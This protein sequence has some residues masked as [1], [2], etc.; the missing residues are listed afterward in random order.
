MAI[1]L[2]T[3]QMIKSRQV[4]RRQKQ[5][6]KCNPIAAVLIAETAWDMEH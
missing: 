1:P 6:M 2:L 5:A 3:P 4:P